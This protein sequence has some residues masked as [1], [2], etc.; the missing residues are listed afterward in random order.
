MKMKTINFEDWIINICI[1]DDNH[2]NIY[3]E[4]AYNESIN[5]IDT[6]QGDG[7]SEQLALRFTTP[8]IESGE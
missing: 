1:D 4:N 5:Q 7:D 2:L 8:T 6:G 3:L